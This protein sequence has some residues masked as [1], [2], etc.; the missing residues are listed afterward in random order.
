MLGDSAYSLMQW[1]MKPY[2]HSTNNARKIKFNVELSRG[3]V[4]IERAFG[5]LKGRWRILMKR[6]DFDVDF[7]SEIFLCACILHNICQD[8][9]ELENDDISVVLNDD[10]V[11]HNAENNSGDALREII[12][13]YVNDI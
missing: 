7:T 8:A 9:K 2:E 3:R 11:A 4:V 10:I 5:I 13:H 12:S 6:M 1:L